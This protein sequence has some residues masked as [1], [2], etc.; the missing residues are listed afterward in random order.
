MSGFF[1]HAGNDGVPPLEPDRFDA[2]AGALLTRG[3][4]V[5]STRTAAAT[6]FGVHHGWEPSVGSGRPLYRDG[7]LLVAAD[8]SLYYKDT[9]LR[10]SGVDVDVPDASDMSAAACIAAAYRT[11]GPGLLDWLEGDFAFVLWD[12]RS[13]RLLAARDPFGCRSLFWTDAVGGIALSSLLA[14]LRDIAGDPDLDRTDLI[15]AILF[16]HGEGTGTP[17]QGIRELP[18]GWMLEWEPG[19]SPSARRYWYPTARPEWQ[20]GSTADG[21]RILA[22]LLRDAAVERL[23]PANRPT[24]IGMSGGRDSTAIVGSLLGVG[25]PVDTDRLEVLSF[26]YPEGDPGNEDAYVRS[27][28]ARLGVRVRWLDT[29]VM[30]I[31]ERSGVAGATRTRPEPQPFEGQNRAL[32]SAALDAGAPVLLN[33]NGGDNLFGL[34]DSW[35]ADLL[36]RGRMVR[37]LRELRQKGYRRPRDVADVVVRP[38]VPLVVMDWIERL[39]GRRIL[40]RPWEAHAPPWI[41]AG[42]LAASGI[43]EEDRATYN[44]DIASRA[45]SVTDR[46]R[47]WAFLYSGFTRNCASLFD[48][49]LDEGVELRMPF[50][51]TRVADFAWSR[52]PSD[53]NDRRE[54]KVILRHAMTGVLPDEVVA[55]RPRRTGT[56]D[57]Y[58]RRAAEREFEP[59]ARGLLQG[60][61]LADLG[62][63]DPGALSAAV[64]DWVK[65]V[66]DHELVLFTTVC[67]EWWIRMNER[68]SWSALPLAGKHALA[69][70]H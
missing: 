31:I 47:M 11:R 36:R 48:M 28:E 54:H 63:V 68:T 33:G 35:L 27:I 45:T 55:P 1:L 15:R 40:S 67:V 44:R 65:G 2:L 17:W 56:S 58:F 18:A 12:G 3:T 42:V 52:P 32:A 39:R 5:E 19:R 29:D 4:E 13:R 30:P 14:P 41:P 61:R 25:E 53:L 50:Y 69:T 16:Q 34:A 70:A 6:A 8:A 60:S 49:S 9:L 23:A 21:G 20:R 7:H 51:D 59:F 43:I 62:L 66:R 38:A 24:A 46:F 64:D 22:G 10:R 26:G 37:L 57:G